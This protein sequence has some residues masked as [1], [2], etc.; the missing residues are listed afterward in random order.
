MPKR[1]KP[2]P[3]KKPKFWVEVHE[4]QEL[5]FFSYRTIRQFKGRQPEFGEFTGEFDTYEEARSV[6]EVE[7]VEKYGDDPYA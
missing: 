5:G 1:I 2:K 4:N 3:K 7:L 6:G